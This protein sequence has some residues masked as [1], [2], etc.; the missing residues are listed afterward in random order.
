MRENNSLMNPQNHNYPRYDASG[1]GTVHQSQGSS[2]LNPPTYEEAI[3]NLSIVPS[4]SNIPSSNSEAGLNS[5]SQEQSFSQFPENINLKVTSE[6][7]FSSDSLLNDPG[8]LFLFFYSNNQRPKMWVDIVGYEIERVSEDVHTTDADGRHQVVNQTRDRTK[9]YFDL[10]Y[11][12][13]QFVSSTGKI[14]AQNSDSLSEERVKAIL[15]EHTS[16]SNRLKTIVLKKEVD[17]DYKGLTQALTTAIRSK[18]FRHMISINYRLE[19]HKLKVTSD[20]KLSRCLLHRVSKVLCVLSCLCLVA[21]PVAYL[22]R[23]KHERQL[24][25]SFSMSITPE[26]WYNRT[27]GSIMSSLDEAN[28]F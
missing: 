22:Y 3:N 6:G 11:D 28:Y 9:T 7:I 1:S 26:E 27:I 8:L 14:Q 19:N 23:R 2:S 4:K 25:S 5:S 20:S 17:W 18:G 15:A 10:S 12:V 16:D 21:W 24:T 13:S